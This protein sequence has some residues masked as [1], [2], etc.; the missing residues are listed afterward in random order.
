MAQRKRGLDIFGKR[1][2][3]S[4]LHLSR[5]EMI[6]TL[7]S[8]VFLRLQGHISRKV[9]P[10]VGPGLAAVLT[11]LRSF[12]W[13]FG[14]VDDESINVESRASFARML[15]QTKLEKCSAAEISFT[16]DSAEDHRVA[17]PLHI[18][19]GALYDPFS[20]SLRIFSQN[21]T[22]LVLDGYVDST[23]FWPSS[24][25]T[26][27][28][29]SWPNLRKLKVFFNMAAPS[30]EWY[31]DGTP[32]EIVEQFRDHE[33]AKT[34]DP[35][36]TAV[37]KAVQK[38]PVLEEF[39]LETELGYGIGYWEVSYYAPGIK[40]DWDENKD[41]AKKLFEVLDGIVMGRT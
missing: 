31:F 17:E 22:S 4:Y 25:E 40:A 1:W 27:S 18:P 3:N 16:Q 10:V 37:A 5:P 30:G 28:T 7:S 33:D 11:N 35:F 24:L 15:E 36:I 14:E 2:V 19:I 39:L 13:E 41:D 20:A 6:P 32:G 8:I 12:Y 34:L 29:P 26:S 9:A 23:L 21:L 38:M